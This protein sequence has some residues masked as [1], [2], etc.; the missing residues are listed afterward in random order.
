MDVLVRAAELHDV[1]KIA[2]PEE[3][4]HKPGPLDE[5]EWELMR[6]HTLIGERILG[7]A[8]AMA[9]IAAAVRWS[10]ERWDGAGYPDGI[11]GEE[12]P[13]AARIVFVCDAYDA[14]RTSR[15]Y[16]R[17][18]SRE[19]AIAELR[20]G[21]GSQFDPRIVEIFCSVLPPDEPEVA[22]PSSGVAVDT[23][24][25]LDAPPDPAPRR[26][27]LERSPDGTSAA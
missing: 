20:R 27:P 15:P 9:P 18:I 22:E 24:S 23:V 6:K 11:A 14:M 8:P 16:R 10:H 13:L 1:G 2:I 7:A 21:A 17:A 12:I 19:Q 25:R 5:L 3:I 26:V 4:L